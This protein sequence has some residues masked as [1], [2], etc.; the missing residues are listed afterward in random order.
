MAPVTLSH[1]HALSERQ[2]TDDLLERLTVRATDYLPYMAAPLPNMAAPLPNMA[3]P[4]PNM[5]YGQ[6]G[7]E[8]VVRRLAAQ[9]TRLPL[10]HMA[11][12]PHM[13]SPP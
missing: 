2:A 4:L 12:L 5:A 11:A 7:E 9:I 13:A 8:D 3:P 10:P 6:L 1:T